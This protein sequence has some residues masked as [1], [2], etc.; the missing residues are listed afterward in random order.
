MSVYSTRRTITI[1][2]R[3]VS[4]RQQLLTRFTLAQHTAKRVEQIDCGLIKNARQQF[5]KDVSFSTTGL[6]LLSTNMK[7]YRGSLTLFFPLHPDPQAWVWCVYIRPNPLRGVSN[8]PWSP[9]THG[10]L[11]L[12][13]ESWLTCSLV[14]EVLRV[15]TANSKQSNVDCWKSE[16]LENYFI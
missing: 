12:W 1:S 9:Q 7:D 6:S 5:C 11:S 2:T 13:E 14:L 4:T 8:I 15:K 10:W 3:N 16:Q